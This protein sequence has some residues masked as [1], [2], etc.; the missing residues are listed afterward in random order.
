[1]IQNFIAYITIS[2]KPPLMAFLKRRYSDYHYQWRYNI[3]DM[4]KEEK[5]TGKYQ[6]T[7]KGKHVT[8]QRYGLFSASER[9][10]IM[11]DIRH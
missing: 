5:V 4:R 6:L 7:V 9:P 10:S 2:I 8:L 11:F 3:L 1:M